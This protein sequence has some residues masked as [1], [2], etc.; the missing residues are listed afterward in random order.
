MELSDKIIQNLVA[1]SS[2]C[3]RG[4]KITVEPAAMAELWADVAAGH[5]YLKRDKSAPGSIE[6][7]MMK[8]QDNA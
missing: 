7:A 8:E 5:T 2:A 6:A 4:E 1:I 3:L